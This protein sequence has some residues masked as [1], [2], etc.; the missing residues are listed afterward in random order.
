MIP[1]Q[2][3]AQTAYARLF[4]RAIQ[5]SEEAMD[6]IATTLAFHMVVYGVETGGAK[7]HALT[8]DELS[9]G[10]FRAAG[11]RFDFRDRQTSLTH[12][13]VCRSELERALQVLAT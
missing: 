1:M 6:I 8:P 12:L 5:A 13:Q 11:S 4:H 2:E 3:A 10:L 7:R 9:A